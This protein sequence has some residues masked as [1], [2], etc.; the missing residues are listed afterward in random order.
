MDIR[1]RL[2]SLVSR[3]QSLDQAGLSDYY[4]FHA[5]PSVNKE[6]AIWNMLYNP[7]MASRLQSYRVPATGATRPIR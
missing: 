4:D 5:D 3:Q 6:G 2:T 7:L 1:A